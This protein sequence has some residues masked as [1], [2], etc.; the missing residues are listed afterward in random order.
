MND[1]AKSISGITKVTSQ[2]PFLTGNGVLSVILDSGIDY[3]NEEFQN[4]MGSTRIVGIWDLTY[5]GETSQAPEGYT[6]GRFYTKEEIQRAITEK[7]SSLVPVA[8]RSGHGTAVA[9]VMAGTTGGIAKES[10]ILVIKLDSS[11]NELLTTSLMRGVDFAVKYAARQNQPAVL[12]ISIGNNYGD[13]Q[14]NSLL[15]RFMDNAAEVG[16]T[17]IVA[18]SGNEGAAGG[19]RA[20]ILRQETTILLSIADFE[21]NLLIQLWKYVKDDFRITIMAPD[22]NRATV[23]NR[24]ALESEKRDL[25]FGT[26]RILCYLGAPLPYQQQQEFLFQFMTTKGEYIQSGIWMFML[27]P[28]SVI[29]GQYRFYLSGSAVRNR[30]TAFLRPTPDMTLTI[31][32]TAQKVITAG[33]YDVAY[34]SYADFSGRGYVYRY[35]DQS[36]LEAPSLIAAVKPDL[37]A[38]GV[39]ITVPTPGGGYEEVSGTSFAAPFTAGMAALLMEWGIVRNNAPYLYGEKLKAFLIKNARRL[40]AYQEYPNPQVGWGALDLQTRLD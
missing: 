7:D 34:E 1:Y 11:T 39:N 8:D 21:S 6:K 33:A 13:H 26:T 35:E 32:S 15:E 40:S 9:G 31:P 5:A 14:G 12:N 19:H 28:V 20:G 24:S 18:G 37:V 4:E 10:D 23:E 25:F 29:Q 16:K 2:Y 38:P 22:G 36:T 17:A 3:Q 30:R 27:E